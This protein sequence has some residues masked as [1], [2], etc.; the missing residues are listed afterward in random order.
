MYY[1][2]PDSTSIETGQARVVEITTHGYRLSV[3][4]EWKTC[5]KEYSCTESFDQRIEEPKVNGRKHNG[6]TGCAP[7]V[8]SQSAEPRNACALL[9]ALRAS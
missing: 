5:S 1:N 6:N 3:L 9:P 8:P 4:D 2:A 7:P